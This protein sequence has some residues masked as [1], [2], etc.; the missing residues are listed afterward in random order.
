ML[1]EEWTSR[2]LPGGLWSPESSYP[3]DSFEGLVSALLAGPERLERLQGPV[4]FYDDY[5]LLGY[6]TGDRWLARRYQGTPLTHISFTGVPIADYRELA[7]YFD[8]PLSAAAIEE[9]TTERLAALHDMNVRDPRE[10]ARKAARLKVEQDLLRR[11]S[12][13]LSVALD[14]DGASLRKD[15]ALR[16]VE[17]A[18]LGATGTLRCAPDNARSSG[19]GAGRGQVPVPARAV[20]RGAAAAR[21]A[22]A[23]RAIWN[24]AGSL[25]GLGQ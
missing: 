20:T 6:G 9:L 4:I 22:A 12:L 3:I 25:L 8:P 24:G 10:T 11:M 14:H 17:G 23:V 2:R 21:S 16:F 13:A 7:H 19:T 18:S 1:G 5:E 15:E